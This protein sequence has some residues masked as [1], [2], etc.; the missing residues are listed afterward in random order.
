ML[1]F[2]NIFVTLIEG[3]FRFAQSSASSHTQGNH[4][5]VYPLRTDLAAW[6]AGAEESVSIP[7]LCNP[8]RLMDGT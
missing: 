3:Y 2:D 4:P 7:P 1:A 5:D 6:V 8:Y